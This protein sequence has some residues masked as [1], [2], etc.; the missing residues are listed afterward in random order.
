MGK[1][2]FIRRYLRRYRINR[3]WGDSVIVATWWALRGKS[4]STFLTRELLGEIL[5]GE[6]VESK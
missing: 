1:T 5:N 2:T 4:F 3:S 6:M